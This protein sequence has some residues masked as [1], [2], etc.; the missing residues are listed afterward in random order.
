MKFV[1]GYLVQGSSFV[2]CCLCER[3]YL[4]ADAVANE[5]PDAPPSFVC[6]RCSAEHDQYELEMMRAEAY[7]AARM[8][9]NY[10][11]S[12]CG[13][14]TSDGSNWCGDCSRFDQVYEEWM[15]DSA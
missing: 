12:D 9:D 5:H 15:F 2:V 11:C 13:T 14:V 1:D 3:E 7:R 8:S 10:F 6:Y 4:V